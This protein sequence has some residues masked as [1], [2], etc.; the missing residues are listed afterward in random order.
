HVVITKTQTKFFEIP[1]DKH[2]IPR[3]SL[4]PHTK[5]KLLDNP[6]CGRD[7]NL[8]CANVNHF[9]R[10]WALRCHEFH[11]C[12]GRYDRRHSKRMAWKGFMMDSDEKIRGRHHYPLP[13][14]APSGIARISIFR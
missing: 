11:V 13:S 5:R 2:L 7:P 4:S 14:S 3:I 1:T 12:A 10:I 6:P 8:L 9:Q